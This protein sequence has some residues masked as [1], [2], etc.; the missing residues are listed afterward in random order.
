MKS[1]ARIAPAWAAWLHNPSN[2][3]SISFA[4]LQID[5]TELLCRAL[6]EGTDPDSPHTYWGE[7]DHYSQHIVEAADVAIALWLSRERVFDR[8]SP[9]EQARIMTWLAKV[10]GKHTY[11]DN[12]ILFPAISLMVRLKLGFPAS[13][14]DLDSRLDQIGRFYRGD[15]WYADGP[16]NEFELYNA[17]MFGWHYLLWAWIDGERRPAVRQ[18]VLRRA[19]SFIRGFPYFFG[20]NGA[21]PAWGRSIVYRFSAVSAFATS[22]LLGIAPANPGL[23][24]RIS[25]GCMRYFYQHGFLDPEQH[26]IYQGFHGHF[27]QAGESYISP[28]SPYWACHALFA[29]SFDRQ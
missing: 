23:L 6:L 20:S 7:M 19:Q 11:F 16:G 24:R 2:P 22:Y 5:L 3:S 29:L 12:W 21:Y 28:G 15:G 10:D 9:S 27:P 4:G 17:W 25:S 8:L 13:V 26:Y 1:F 14:R 18:A